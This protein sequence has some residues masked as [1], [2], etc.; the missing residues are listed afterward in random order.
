MI[1]LEGTLFWQ[2]P[3]WCNSKTIFFSFQ[4]CITGGLGIPGTQKD[5]SSSRNVFV[6]W[7]FH[8]STKQIVVALG[9]EKKDLQWS[10]DTLFLFIVINFKFTG[11]SFKDIFRHN[12]R[13]LQ[14]IFFCCFRWLYLYTLQIYI[15]ILYAISLNPITTFKIS[16][17]T[18]V[19]ADTHACKCNKIFTILCCICAF[20]SGCKLSV[21]NISRKFWQR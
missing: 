9:R 13:H 19:E 17:V 15:Y 16:A 2:L 20:N 12:P 14:F 1:F 7:F 18:T 21:W 6:S 8:A 5:P 11:K 4:M 3:I 10:V